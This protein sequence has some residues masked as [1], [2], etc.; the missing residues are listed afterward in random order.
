MRRLSERSQHEYDAVLRCGVAGDQLTPAVEAW[1][2]SRRIVLR[3]ALRHA[4]SLGQIAPD[5]MQRLVA[6]VPIE[7]RTPQRVQELPSMAEVDRLR[8]TIGAVRSPVW[9]AIHTLLLETGMRGSELLNL[10]RAR[11]T[12][13]AETGWINVL[14]KGDKERRVPARAVQNH[15]N[16]LLQTSTR[17]GTQ[18]E[19]VGDLIQGG[20]YKINTLNRH[21]R[22][23]ATRAGLNLHLHS[24]RACYAS[25]LHRRGVSLRTIQV[26]LGHESLETTQRYLAIDYDQV[27][28]SL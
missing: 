10:S 6:A 28:P 9:R 19:V 8:E 4:A 21:V 27:Q 25:T 13:G 2:Y 18:W 15:L 23:L 24:L 3:A 22:K 11:V 7:V 20:D 16:T 1:S 17:A 12:R 5:V 14:G 26:L